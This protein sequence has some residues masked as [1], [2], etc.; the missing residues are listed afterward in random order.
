MEMEL[1]LVFLIVTLLIPMILA[2]FA[3]DLIRSVIALLIGSVGLALVL[4]NLNASMA[5]IFELSVGAG[6]IAVLF[7]LSIS[8]TRPLTKETQTERQKKHYRRFFVLPF[9]IVILAV[10]FYFN[11]EQW[12]SA[13]NYNQIKDTATVG[14]VLWKSRGLDLIGQIGILLVGVFGV[15]VLFKR[16]KMNE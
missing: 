6:L 9:I 8:L 2:V 11:R 12:M 15:V 16:G 4:F 7:I 5:G 14:N 1:H 13:F 10:L 3:S